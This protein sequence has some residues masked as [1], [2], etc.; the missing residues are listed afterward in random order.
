MLG[1]SYYDWRDNQKPFEAFTSRD[2]PNTCD[3]TERQ[4]GAAELRACRSQFPADFW[5]S[6]LSAGAIFCPRKTAPTGRRVALISYGFWRAHYGL[7]PGILNR[8]IDLDGKPA[9]V[10]GVLPR[11]FE[12]PSLEP[13]DILVAE[14]LDE[15]AQR[16][17]MPGAVLYAFARL[18]PGVSIAQAEGC[19][20]SRSSTIPLSLAPPQF[21]SEVHL[22]VRPCATARWKTCDWRHGCCWVRCWR[23]C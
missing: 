12:M 16:K 19:S 23:C 17:A 6:R 4:S 22:R 5:V 10:V 21:R 13:A 11:D 2:D 8:L 20:C 3:L 1:G 15:A 14:A 18:K 9:R 7:D